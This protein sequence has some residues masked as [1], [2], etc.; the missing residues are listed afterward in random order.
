VKTAQ[1]RRAPAAHDD[2]DDNDDS[3]LITALV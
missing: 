1:F 2:D 3:D